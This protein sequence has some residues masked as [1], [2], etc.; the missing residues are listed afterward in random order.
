MQ[1]PIRDSRSRNEQK[2]ASSL[3]DGPTE[4]EKPTWRYILR[5]SVREFS[6]DE[7][8]DLAAGLAFHAVLS[9]FPAMLALVSLLGLFGQAEKT[10]N[11]IIDVIES[12]APGEV[13]D[14]ARGVI[15]DLVNS[16][17]AGAALS[18]GILVAVWSASGYV[19]AFSRAMNRIYAVPEGR[20]FWKLLPSLVL[21]T[22]AII[23]LVG[24][25]GLILALSGPVLKAVGDLVGLGDELI[26][27]WN[28]VKWP[29]LVV[30][31]IIT[32]ALLYYFTPNVKQPKFRW[33]SLG[34]TLS[35][36]LMAVASAGFAFYV[37]NFS[38][39][40]KTYGTIGAVIVMLLW[41]WIMNLALLFGAEFDSE[42]ERGRELQAGIAAEEHLQLPL[43]DTSRFVKKQE[44]RQKSIAQGR[45]IRLQAGRDRAPV[46]VGR[47]EQ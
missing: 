45:A 27:I 24:I 25:M 20:P 41:V 40:N 1:G 37:A 12:V 43:R 19:R 7:C 33:I 11:A 8:T 42:T 18:V 10:T 32:L 9:V 13:T 36:V 23:V 47:N 39:Y 38:S 5:T 30:L 26:F 4:V 2:V 22:V 17:T 34:A 46:G 6:N 31:M 3:P 44:Q 21:M 35:L 28:I 15:E 14:L 16:P 29:I